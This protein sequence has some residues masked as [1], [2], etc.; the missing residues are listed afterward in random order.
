MCEDQLLALVD[1][2]TL[3]PWQVLHLQAS[4]MMINSLLFLVVSV[5]WQVK[6]RKGKVFQGCIRL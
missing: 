1:T 2:A 3:A 6:V 4:I 5:A